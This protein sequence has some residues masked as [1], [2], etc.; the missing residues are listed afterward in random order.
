[1]HD[2][3]AVHAAQHLLGINDVL[4]NR[5]I[6]DIALSPDGEAAAVVIERP[7]ATAKEHYGVVRTPAARRR[8]I[9]IV[10][11]RGPVRNITHGDRDGASFWRPAW[12]PDGRR[13]AMLSTRGNDNIRIY[14]WDEH[15]GTLHRLLDGGAQLNANWETYQEPMAWVS[16]TAL[17]CALAPLGEPSIEFF[18]TNV[19]RRVRQERAW[20]RAEQGVVSTASVL[21]GGIATGEPNRPQGELVLANVASG[22]RTPLLHANVRQ[23]AVSPTGRAVAVTAEASNIAF[24][25]D[26]TPR[27]DD[28]WPHA[29][30][31]M[32][33]RLAVIQLDSQP[34][35]HWVNSL[36]DPYTGLASG[37]W[38]KDG[39]ML[40]VMAHT[41]PADGSP[42]AAFIVDTNGVVHP[43]EGAGPTT[44]NDSATLRLAASVWSG[45]DRIP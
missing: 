11:R 38:T 12:S 43:G 41:T 20:A 29:H 19:R 2:T 37:G 33:R 23:I 30:F 35:V 5:A 31:Y 27:W 26:Q 24:S 28:D 18:A 44:A 39:T 14:L 10:S 16:P 1:M 7:A 8:H 17:L 3:L 40:T 9:W 32:H 34:A 36:N 21:E 13:L 15:A 22:R 45:W 4:A 6:D 25:L 42:L